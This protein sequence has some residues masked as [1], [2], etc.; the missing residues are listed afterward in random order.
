M[1]ARQVPRERPS[2]RTVAANQMNKVKVIWKK[3]THITF[4]LQ[5]W[6]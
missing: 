2:S 5:N 4:H 3:R 1:I 6:S